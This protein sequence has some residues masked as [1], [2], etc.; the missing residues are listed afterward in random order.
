MEAGEPGNLNARESATAAAARAWR[1]RQLAK[2]RL[3]ERTA[4][5]FELMFACGEALLKGRGDP[6]P[7]RLAG[8]AARHPPD[9]RR[10]LELL[11]ENRFLPVVGR[12][13]RAAHGSGVPESLAGAVAERSKKDSLRALRMTA[14][15]I[16]LA[17]KFPESG[18]RFIAFKGPALAMQVHGDP[19]LRLSKDLDLLVAPEDHERAERLLI[20]EGYAYAPGEIPFKA[21]LAHRIAAFHSHLVH[22]EN[23]TQV[24]LH[25]GLLQEALPAMPPFDVLWRER[26]SVPIAGLAVPTLPLPWHGL[27]LILHGEQHGWER[28]IRPF[29]VA[30]VADALGPG[31]SA[32]M[33]ALAESHGQRTRLRNGLLLAGLLFGRETR[34]AEP[35]RPADRR[36]EAYVERAFRLIVAPRPAAERPLGRRYWLR[37]R[38]RWAA[39]LTAREKLRYLAG[40]FL[41]EDVDIARTN[42]PERLFFLHYALKPF[43]AFKRKL[44]GPAE[45][46]H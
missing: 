3:D 42:L 14:E 9:W 43:W 29:D 46:P 33:A 38:I 10:F 13:L 41:P 15:L 25:F 22:R 6:D 7:G 36:A 20:K 24:E 18:L 37:K 12:A 39:C 30:A 44:D 1:S 11:H 17:G 31:G 19:A 45:R 2:S 28:L 21:G 8:L 35:E 27:Y 5:E 4:L 16:R 26:A 32:E 34:E 23:H 40:H